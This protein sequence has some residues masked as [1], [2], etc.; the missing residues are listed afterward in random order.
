MILKNTLAIFIVKK[1]HLKNDDTNHTILCEVMWNHFKNNW[2]SR[3]QIEKTIMEV[4]K[5]NREFTREINGNFLPKINEFN[6]LQ[7]AHE[8]L[9]FNFKKKSE[10]FEKL[11]E[12]IA[13]LKKEKGSVSDLE[14]KQLEDIKVGE[15]W[16]QTI[17]EET[18]GDYK[19]SVGLYYQVHLKSKVFDNWVCVDCDCQYN[20]YRNATIERRTYFHNHPEKNMSTFIETITKRDVFNS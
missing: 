10:E 4:K 19:K 15:K 3:F 6:Q 12:E 7:T 16:G 1:C 9:T 11:K 20:K 14:W 17:C 8:T 13:E 2:M 18:R 5:E